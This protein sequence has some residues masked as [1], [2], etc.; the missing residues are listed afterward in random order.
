MS[1]HRSA[2]ILAAVGCVAVFAACGGGGGTSSPGAPVVTG[3]TPAPATPTPVPTPT[4]T[5]STQQVVTMALPSSVMGSTTTAFGVIGGYTQSGFSQILA[6]AP[7]S[8]I[9]LRNGQAGV[10]HTLDVV[11]TASFPASP[12]LSTTASGATLDQNFA[13][14][15]INPTTMIG[16][17]TLTAGTYYVGCAFHYTTDNMRTVLVVA[18]GATPG[19]QATPPSSGSTPPPT[20]YGY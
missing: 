15:V 16:P 1:P 10:P 12:T 18:A 20:G 4:A 11:S 2:S 7:G 3:S 19:P 5:V 14:G 6:F 8:Q 9:M 13:S 17:F